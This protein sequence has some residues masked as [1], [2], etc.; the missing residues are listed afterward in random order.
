MTAVAT[1][2]TTSRDALLDAALAEFTAKGY[3]AATVADIAERAGVTTGALYN[4]FEN[5]LDLLVACIGVQTIG[6]FWRKMSEVASLPWNEAARTLGRIY[7]DTPEQSTLLL[8]DVIVLA[9]RD[10]S[11]AAAFGGTLERYLASTA[12]AAHEG[13]NAGLIDPALPPADL[14]RIV[15]ALAFGQLVLDAL[16]QKRPSAASAVQFVD[17]LLQSHHI[18]ARDEPAALALVRTRAAATDRARQRQNA[19]IID[20]AAQG[21]SLRRIGEAAGLSHERVRSIVAEG[22]RNG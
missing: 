9:R 15:T 18:E 8:L 14:A 1:P 12:R 2:R 17:M 5:K 6:D 3:E 10:P 20:A 11:V 19:A 7:S 16:G 4:Q 13:H 22:N 21:H